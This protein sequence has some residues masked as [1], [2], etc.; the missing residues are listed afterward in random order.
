MLRLRLGE[1]CRLRRWFWLLAK[2]HDSL[3]TDWTPTGVEMDIHDRGGT[4]ILDEGR[5]GRYGETQSQDR[6][7]RSE[8]K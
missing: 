2:R 5:E 8:V 3:V 4:R 6:T 7:R 1:L